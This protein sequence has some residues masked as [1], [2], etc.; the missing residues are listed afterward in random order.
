MFSCELDFSV[1]H[2]FVP[3][4]YPSCVNLPILLCGLPVLKALR[5]HVDYKKYVCRVIDVRICARLRIAIQVH[6][7]APFLRTHMCAHTC[8]HWAR[9]FPHNG[10]PDPFTLSA[11][12]GRGHFS[13][14]LFLSLR[15]GP[16]A[17]WAP[18]SADAGSPRRPRGQPPC[19]PAPTAARRPRARCPPAPARWR[20]ARLT[21]SAR[22]TGAAAT[23]A[24]PTP[25]WRPC[26]PRQVGPGGRGA[27]GSW[28]TALPCPRGHTGPPAE[29]DLAA[30]EQ[31]SSWAH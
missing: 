28:G 30:P 26:R 23:T 14:G 5:E 25:A 3:E 12:D 20:A 6:I 27:E 8:T 13:L 4:I 11:V 29:W 24:V 15:A 10:S 16:A 2:Y 7:Q 21:P 17:R 18:R 22:A 9:R 31:A 1:P 19:S